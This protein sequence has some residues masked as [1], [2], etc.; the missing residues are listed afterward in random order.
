[1]ALTG[2]TIR[3]AVTFVDFNGQA[4]EA[5]EPTIKVYTLNKT[6]LATI[7]LTELH[8]TGPGAYQVDY[9]VPSGTSPLIIEASGNVEGT[10]EV[11][12]WMVS[13]EWV[14]P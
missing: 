8:K 1:M 9:T 10:P 11:N 6:E 7:E 4:A 5:T 2:N 14:A 12:R 13:R 3:L